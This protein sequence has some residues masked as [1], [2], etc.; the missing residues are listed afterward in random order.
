MRRKYKID[1]E[2]EYNYIP[3][4]FIEDEI[5]KMRHS[6][7][8]EEDPDRQERLELYC[9]MLDCLIQKWRDYE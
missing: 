9:T 5:A 3:V 8:K 7:I 6:W 2:I 4:S 1:Y